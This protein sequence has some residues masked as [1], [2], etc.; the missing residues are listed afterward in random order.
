MVKLQGGLV[1]C[2]CP[3]IDLVPM[4]VQQGSDKT[5]DMAFGISIGRVKLQGL[6]CQGIKTL[7]R[8]DVSC[9]GYTLSEVNIPLLTLLNAPITAFVVTN[10]VF[11]V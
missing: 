1:H 5:S 9:W 7:A 10:A 6:T 2:T 3:V 8:D 4:S 11:Q